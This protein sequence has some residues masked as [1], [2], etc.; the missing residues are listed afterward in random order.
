MGNRKTDLISI[1][2]PVYNT[3]KYLCECVDSLLAQT[4]QNIEV[5]LV[6]D[7]SADRSP[8]I[9]D[10][11]AGKDARIKV[12][13]KMNGGAS[14][15][16]NAGIK[17]SEGKWILF[18][19]SDDFCDHNM[20]KHMLEIGMQEDVPLIVATGYYYS[21][22]NKNRI[23]PEQG[24]KVQRISSAQMVN[25]WL[26]STN[27]KTVLFTIPVSK[28]YNADFFEDELRFREGIGYEDEEF[29][30][31][32]YLK[33]YDLVVWDEPLYYYRANTESITYKPFSE[34]RCI[35]LQL[36]FERYEQYSAK[37][38]ETVARKAAK[39]FCE[40]YLEYGVLSLEQ[41]HFEWIMKYRREF[42]QMRK[43]LGISGYFKDQIRYMIFETSPMVYKRIVLK[44]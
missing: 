11:Y 31:R 28:L 33:D 25:E 2:V 9:C 8:T 42:K 19:D 32:L 13:H 37:G 12:I 7:G 5:I 10:E 14:S 15:A 27:E 17:A 41:N 40:I 4:Y 43:Q 24:T 3:E 30:T 34:A 23:T 18:V 44:K 29:S 35:V 36:L 6:D 20:C 26:W 39:N 21:V 22:E 16:R 38:W 1:I